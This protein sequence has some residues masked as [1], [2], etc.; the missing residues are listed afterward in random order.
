MCDLERF[1]QI[2]SH[3]HNVLIGAES[4]EQAYHKAKAI[5]RRASMNLYE[6]NSNSNEFLELLLVD[7]RSLVS[8]DKFKILGLF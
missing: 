7:K 8:T 5:F 2:Q 3:I 6:L 4:A 1:S